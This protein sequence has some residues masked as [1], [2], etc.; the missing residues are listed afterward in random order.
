MDLLKNYKYDV[1]ISL[2][3]QDAEYARSL[4]AQIN[5]SLNVFFYEQNQEEIISKSGPEVFASVFKEARVV[6]ILSRKEWSQTFYTELEMH[7][8]TD[9]YKKE[10][11]GFLVVVPMLPG[12]K[13]IWYPET[14]I[15]ADPLSMSL[16]KIATVV[17]YR[18]TQ[19]G[20]IVKQLTLEDNYEHLQRRIEE[21]K[22][23]IR[24]QSTKEAIEEVDKEGATIYA[25]VQQKMDFLTTGNPAGIERNLW[26]SPNVETFF[27][28][29]RY[30]LEIRFLKPDIMYN[31]IVSTQ[32]YTLV[33]CISRVFGNL[34]NLYEQSENKKPIKSQEYKYLYGTPTKGWATPYVP[35]NKPSAADKQVLFSFKDPIRMQETHYHYDL[36]YPANAAILIDKWYS[37]LLNYAASNIKNYI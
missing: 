28:M 32:D 34:R 14:L 4:K 6:V 10:G 27:R 21:K 7:A 35:T 3:N 2:C 29:G 22:C 1:A 5:P 24:L 31:K 11:L 15:Y 23:A 8:I 9:R 30:I 26:P 33:I 17:E 13:P 37:E 19:S 16:E 12:E 36:R 18:V 20:G 25:L